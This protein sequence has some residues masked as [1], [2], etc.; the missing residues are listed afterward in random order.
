MRISLAN[1][2]SRKCV[3][4]IA[5]C[6]LLNLFLAPDDSMPTDRFLLGGIDD[7]STVPG[8]ATFS[9]AHQLTVDPNPGRQLETDPGTSTCQRKCS[10]NRNKIYYFDGGAGL[11]DRAFVFRKLAALA[12][13]LCA[14]LVLP[15]PRKLLNKHHNNGKLVEKSVKWQDLY[16]LTYI[17]DFAP[18][19]KDGYEEFGDDFEGWHLPGVFDS[20]SEGSKY[21]GWKHVISTNP[22]IRQGEFESLLDFTYQQELDAMSSSST[23]PTKGFI[24]E[25]NTD[26]YH[27]NILGRHLPDPS[28][29]IRKQAEEAGIWNATMRP[30]MW[31][32][33]TNRQGCHYTPDFSSSIHMDMMKK[34]IQDFIRSKYPKG[35]FFG[36]LQIRRGDAIK[37]CD[38]RLETMKEFFACSLNGT[39]EIG[40]HASLLMTSDE[41]DPTYRQAIMDMIDDYPNVSILDFDATVSKMVHDA[42]EE[43]SVPEGMDNNNFYIFE[44]EVAFKRQADFKML[45]RREM[46]CDDCVPVKEILLEKLMGDND[47]SMMK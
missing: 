11:S 33:G 38:S 23:M 6:A 21:K 34:R 46:W 14:E 3:G 15:P 28:Q 27:S 5:T 36:E 26:F 13:Y 10:H 8:E 7:I 18:A 30:Y 20:T 9:T 45:K 29:P 42:V 32:V 37:A 16:N 39:E 4:F 24:W 17:Q 35:T 12:G 2:S 40:R 44:I 31:S 25:W 47:E 19:I 41:V 1:A 22:Y 43:G